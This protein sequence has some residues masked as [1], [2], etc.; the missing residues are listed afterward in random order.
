M[1]LFL[2]F[3]AI[4]FFLFIRQ[5]RDG[6]NSNETQAMS[7]KQVLQKQ[8]LANLQGK[9]Q[10]IAGETGDRRDVV[11]LPDDV[12]DRLQLVF[13]DNKVVLHGGVTAQAATFQL[14][15]TRSPKW[16]DMIRVDS[17]EKGHVVLGIYQ[18]NGDNL[19]LFWTNPAKGRPTSFTPKSGQMLF[20]LKRIATSRHPDAMPLR[21]PSRELI[22]YE[23]R[24]ALY[25]ENE[26]LARVRVHGIRTT[27][28]GMSATIT[29]LPTRGCTIGKGKSEWRIGTV[30]D[31]SS[32]FQKN[33][34][35]SSHGNW[36][37]KFHGQLIK[38]VIAI[39]EDTSIDDLE[40]QRRIKKRYYEAP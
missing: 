14:D 6:L 31:T 21:N 35:H 33:T 10:V 24:E 28:E 9:W 2:L 34:W 32:T 13:T 38:D 40:C 8:E 36:T 39:S 19:Q 15:P 5:G 18:L 7:D 26:I 22:A 37:L 23:G 4:T 16:I 17:A 25:K 11:P 29:V 12:V 27:A 20:I 1:S 3:L 30:W